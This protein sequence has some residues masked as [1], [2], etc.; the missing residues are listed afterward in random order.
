MVKCVLNIKKEIDLKVT[1]EAVKMH[2]EGYAL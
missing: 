1:L 2:L